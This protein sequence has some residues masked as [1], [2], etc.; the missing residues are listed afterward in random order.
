MAG[1]ANLTTTKPRAP[2]RKPLQP[3]TRINPFENETH[4]YDLALGKVFPSHPSLTLFFIFLS[5]FALFTKCT[6]LFSFSLQLQ[7]FQ[8]AVFPSLGEAGAEKT[9]AQFPRLHKVLCWAKSYPPPSRNHLCNACC[10]LLSPP[11]CTG[12]WRSPYGCIFIE[13]LWLHWKEQWQSQELNSQERDIW[14][15]WKGYEC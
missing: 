15:G 8:I 4:Q 3:A 2:P 6:V 1:F 9:C 11:P 13:L 7:D 14:M 10:I 5:Y 12:A